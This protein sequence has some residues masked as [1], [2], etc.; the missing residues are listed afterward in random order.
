TGVGEDKVLEKIV[1]I[2]KGQA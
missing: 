2:L 1:S